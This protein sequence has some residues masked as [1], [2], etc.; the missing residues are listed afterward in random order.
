VG[1]VR[2]EVTSWKRKGGGELVHISKW[3]LPAFEGGG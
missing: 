3:V 2:R 1:E